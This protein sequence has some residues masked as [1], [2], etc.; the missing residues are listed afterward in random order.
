M[1][2]TE[3]IKKMDDEERVS[4]KLDALGGMQ[5]MAVVNKPGMYSLIF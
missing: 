2:K 3:A 1:F 4:I 5:S